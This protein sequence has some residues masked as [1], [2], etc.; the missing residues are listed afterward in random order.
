MKRLLL[1]IAFALSFLM[2]SSRAPAEEAPTYPL[3]A[4]Y[5]ALNAKFSTLC[6]LENKCCTSILFGL[7]KKS[8]CTCEGPCSTSGGE[9]QCLSK[10]K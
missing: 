2:F 8:C 9:C 7:L 3:L 10:P 5:A 6:L 4:T 1:P